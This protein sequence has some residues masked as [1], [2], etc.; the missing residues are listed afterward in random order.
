MKKFF[1]L[2]VGISYFFILI[3]ILINLTSFSYSDNWFTS[4][5]DYHSSKYS[6]LDQ[7]NDKNIDSLSNA[8]IFE[9]G[10]NPSKKEF[11]YNNQ[12]TPIFTGKSLIV[13]NSVESILTIVGV[14]L[15]ILIYWVESISNQKKKIQ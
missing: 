7:I 1:L 10:F 5:G 15:S 2:N 14:T 9:N 11:F 13:T 8:W 12:A 3:I 6:N 4:S